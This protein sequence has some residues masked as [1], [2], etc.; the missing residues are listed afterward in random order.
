MSLGGATVRHGYKSWLGCAE[1]VAYGTRIT[2]TSY[3][4]FYSESLKQNREPI[5]LESANTSRDATRFLQGN[6]MVEGS[7]EMDLNVAED[8]TVYTL[9]QVMGGTVSSAT[10]TA[11]AVAHTLYAGDMESNQSSA[12]AADTKGLSFSVQRDDTTTGQWHYSGCRMNGI[13]IVG[14]SGQ[15]VKFTGEIIGKTA[16]ITAETHTVSF[17]NYRPLHFTGISITT[18]DSITN[19]SSTCIIGFEFSMAN[20]LIND[21]NAR[22]LGDRTVKKLPASMREVNLK[23]TMRFDTTTAHDN[24]LAQTPIAVKILMDGQSITAGGSNYSMFINTP[25]CYLTDSPDPE[26]SEMGI[27]TQDLNFRCLKSNTTTGYSVQMQINN[28]TAN[29]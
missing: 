5:I 3:I 21:A 19:L 27:I 11:G 12:G 18:G 6:E 13:N 2:A 8:F 25:T 1:E 29:Y 16:T 23:L 28:A 15:P 10:I 17:S 4:E 7:L 9:K 24:F 14:E 22:C 20:N 26:I